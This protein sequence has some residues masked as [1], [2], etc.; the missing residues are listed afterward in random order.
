M[1]Y[2]KVQR[3]IGSILIEASQY[4]ETDFDYIVDGVN[5]LCSAAICAIRAG[6]PVNAIEELLADARQLLK[7][8]IGD[9]VVMTFWEGTWRAFVGR[10]EIDYVG[11]YIETEEGCREYIADCHSI[12]II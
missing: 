12:D 4:S 11:L 6:M 5:E 1:V 8:K 9:L 7:F 2:R 10:L 3:E